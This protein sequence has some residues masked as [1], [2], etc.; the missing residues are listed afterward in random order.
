[1]NSWICNQCGYTLQKDT[2]PEKCPACKAD[3]SFVDNT[4]YTPDCAGETQ[5][6]RIKGENQ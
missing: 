4:C 2:P 1:M 6:P 5:D 3:C